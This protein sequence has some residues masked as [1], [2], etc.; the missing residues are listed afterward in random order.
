MALVR[1]CRPEQ[2]ETLDALM[3]RMEKLEQQI[4]EGM[5]IQKFLLQLM[6]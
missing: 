1:I 3:D 5:V 4:S 6:I 2:E